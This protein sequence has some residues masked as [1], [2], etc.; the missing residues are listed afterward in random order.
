MVEE[1]EAGGV[2][3]AEVT[4]LPDGLGVGVDL[5]DR[6]P[7]AE[8]TAVLRTACERIEG[9][10]VRSVLVIRLRATDTREWPG[11]VPIHEVTQ[12]ERV[13][14]RL[15]GL[16][17]MVVVAG[18]GAV[19]GPA[20]DLLLAADFRIAGADLRL[21]PPVNDG[22]FWPG[23][24]VYRLVHHLGLARARQIVLWGDD[25]PADRAR[26]LGLI[27][28][29]AADPDEAV[30]TATVLMG[31]ISDQELT[32]RRRLLAEA[33]SVGYEEALGVLYRAGTIRTG[34]E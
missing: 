3:T 5:D 27:D 11:V 33:T 34:C 19:G 2:V 31:R 17:A 14:R 4:E 28:Q 16:A 30:H 8:L 6:R 15:E 29:I 26:E 12:W 20:L 23:M 21:L 22:H 25:I 13:L 24:G 32:I 7:L 18:V 9:R 10:G 1:T